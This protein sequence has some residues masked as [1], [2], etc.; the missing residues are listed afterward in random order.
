[1]RKHLLLVTFTLLLSMGLS[2]CGNAEIS[3]EAKDKARGAVENAAGTV[4]SNIGATVQAKGEE[5]KPTLEAKASN[6]ADNVAGLGSVSDKLESWP[7]D[8]LEAVNTLGTQAAALRDDPSLMTDSAWRTETENAIGV[9]KARSQDA[10]D[11]SE[12]LKSNDRLPK[13]SDAL[14]SLGTKMSDSVDTIDKDF[15]D[16]DADAFLKDTGSLEFVTSAIDALQGLVA[17]KSEDQ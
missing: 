17:D 5:L 9:L 11:V 16:H 3:N 14:S 8:V 13:V 12:D 4:E 2:A 10:L 6:V 1:M 7:G 15:Q